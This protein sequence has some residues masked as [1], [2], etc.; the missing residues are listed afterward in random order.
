MSDAIKLYHGLT[1]SE[2][3]VD[4]LDKLQQSFA[5]KSAKYWAQMRTNLNLAARSDKVD[6]MQ[7]EHIRNELSDILD[8][9]ILIYPQTLSQ[10]ALRPEMSLEEKKQEL[11]IEKFGITRTESEKTFLRNMAYKAANVHK[12]NWS[13]RIGQEATE[14][15]E[16]QWYPFFVTLT[17][18]PLKADAEKLWKEGKEFRKY[19]KSLVTMVCKEL[20]H[21]PAHKPP[22]RPQSDYVTYAGV[23]EHGKSREHHHAHFIIW[24]RRIPASW[25]VC[26]N[27]G[28]RN[29]ANRTKN[30]CL[31]LRTYWRWSLPGLSPALYFRSVGDI[32][33]TRHNFVLPLREGRPMAVSTAR[34]AGHYI[35][36][37]LS[38][39]HKEWHHR[40]KSTRNLGMTRLKMILR[41]MNPRIVEPLAWRPKKSNLNNLLMRTHIVPLGLLR[42]EAKRMDYLNKFRERQLDIQI[43]LQNNYGIFNRMLS[44]VRSGA[45]PER[46][47]SSEFYDWVGKH[48]PEI[49]GYCETRLIAAHTAIASFFPPERRQIL[50]VKIGANDIGYS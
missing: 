15:Q 35:T 26:P 18:D 14:K 5:N 21:P 30:E 39:E 42:S 38:K 4:K 11:G 23:I 41:T 50:P 20:G 45:R 49:K 32:W 9:G 3:T 34:V 36:K 40:V 19:I 28:I 17:V 48:L 43:L 12:A 33:E 8:S 1:R 37:Y 29:P 16:E 44:S 22:Y 6:E 7:I 47:D 13:W 25:S 46:M 2:D 31:P 10:L 24:L 27:S